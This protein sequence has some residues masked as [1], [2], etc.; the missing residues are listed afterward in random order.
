MKILSYL[1]FFALLIVPLSFLFSQEDPLSE[2]SIKIIIRKGFFGEHE[3]AERIRVACNHLHWKVQISDFSTSGDTQHFDWILTLVPDKNSVGQNNY[4]VLFDP[5][6]HYF[7]SEG[8]LKRKYTKYSGY[9]TTYM[10]TDLLL[11]DIK[12]SKKRLY[13]KRWYPTAQY[14]PY[15]EVKP[16]R[17][18]Y[19]LG[20]WGN[21][22]EDTRYQ[23]LQKKLAE[24]SYTCFFGDSRIGNSYNKAYLG[25]IQH[26]GE[27]VLNRI[28]ETGVCLVLHSNT[29][30]LNEIP[31]GRLFEAA[32]A[33]AVI[34]SDL[35]SFVIE[36]FGDSVFY[37]DQQLSGD[38][39]F[40]QIDA[41]MTW[42]QNHPEEALKMARR[43]HQIFEEQFLLE[44]QLLD[45][46]KFHR[47]K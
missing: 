26:D 39:M 13:D 42:I 16:D 29:H 15:R 25:T 44:R 30:L 43:A 35:N 18:F 41:H 10:N 40:E 45:F 1:N 8:H 38:E 14:I 47:N 2:R 46:D 7:D 11:K 4:L 33:S 32:A 12:Y 17:L 23:I 19:F 24:K 28:S 5:K 9:L 31:S 6:N 27:S 3:F 37:V 34:I 22:L 36:N 21:R 20:V